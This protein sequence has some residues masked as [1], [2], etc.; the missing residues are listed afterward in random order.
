MGPSWSLCGLRLDLAARLGINL[1]PIGSGPPCC[2]GFPPAPSL[3]WLACLVLPFRSKSCRRNLWGP[4]RQRGNGNGQS[5]SR[6]SKRSGTGSLPIGWGQG[7]PPR[8]RGQHKTPDH[9]AQGGLN[10][11]WLQAAGAGLVG[12]SGPLDRWTQ[13]DA[14]NRAQRQALPGSGAGVA[15]VRTQERLEGVVFIQ[16][17]S[18]AAARVALASARALRPALKTSSE[19][20]APPAGK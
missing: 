6:S 18:P 8:R 16:Q 1:P 13:R 15:V 3:S 19:M 2:P 4:A 9:G 17:C 10:D 11:A 20:P 5:S 7:L 14:A 12:C